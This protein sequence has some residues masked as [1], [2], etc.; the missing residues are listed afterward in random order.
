MEVHEIT[1]ILENK[2]RTLEQQR[3]TAVSSGDLEAVVSLD[4]KI[5]ETANTLALIKKI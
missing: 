2:L 4:S 5:T 1:F 3:S